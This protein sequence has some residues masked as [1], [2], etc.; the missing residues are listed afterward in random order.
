MSTDTQYTPKQETANAQAY[1][2]TA[3]RIGTIVAEANERVFKLQSEAAA[4]ALAD[5]SRLLKTLLDTKDPATAL[6]Q[7]ANLYQ[8]N[9]RR[10]LDV[11][12]SC[13][14]IVPQTQA[15]MAKLVGEPFA[16]YNNAMQQYLDQFTKAVNDGRD[17]AAVAMKDFQVK[18]I[19]SASKQQSAMTKKVA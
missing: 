19:E 12:R 5:S 4:A 15:E 16:S 1:A 9:M 17:A 6:S 14:E 10:V 2:D 18:A 13:F 7:W 3:V 11:T 8:T